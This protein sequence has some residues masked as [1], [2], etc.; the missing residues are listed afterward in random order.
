M[1]VDSPLQRELAELVVAYTSGLATDEQFSRLA[2][3]IG[4]SDEA[5]AFY[6]DSL[7]LHANLYWYRRQQDEH[8]E[9]QSPQVAS[10]LE[11]QSE[12]SSPPPNID[13]RCD[14]PPP[15]V[16]FLNL[17]GVFGGLSSGWLVA[18]S[19]AT[20][21]FG[22]G[23]AIGALV[24]VSQ[25]RHYAGSER[26]VETP[27]RQ[28]AIPNPSPI[29]ARVIGMVDC[30]WEGAG[31]RGPAS[32]AANQKSEIRN[33][34]SLLR[35]GDRLALTSGLLE[36]AYDTGARVI[37]QGPVTYDVESPAGG[38]LAVGKLT[39]KLGKRSEV[40]GPSSLPANQKSEIRNQKFAVRTPA[41]IVT[42]LGTE[43][44]VTVSETGVTQVHVIQGVVEAKGT[45]P[46][47]EL[48]QAKRLTKG[49]AIEIG[50]KDKA[51][52]PVAFAPEQ[53]TRK[54]ELNA[55]VPS[56]V[57]YMTAVLADQP[58]AYWPLNEPAGSRRFADHSDNHVHGWGMRQLASGKPGPMQGESRA[59]ALAGNGG[60][61][62]GRH[63]HFALA[64]DFTVEA[65]I[66]PD[67]NMQFGVVIAATDGQPRGGAG[68]ALCVQPRS[69]EHDPTLPA[70]VRLIT[71]GGSFFDFRVPDR[72]AEDGRWI[73][74]AVV[75]QESGLAQFYLNGAYR[76]SARGQSPRQGE[77]AWVSIGS[78]ATLSGGDWCGRLSHVAV[79]PRA[80]GAEQIRNHHRQ[81]DAGIAGGDRKR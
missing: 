29:V 16:P 48:S 59:V 68:W 66:C 15:T 36:I 61:D 63:D 65:W 34:K 79:Y 4:A 43:F 27:N 3:L 33:H 12:L 73:H 30:V 14:D 23:L 49:Q 52:Q 28:S 5:M 40:R 78:D 10:A 38:Y 37:L 53:F 24:H 1:S 80:L 20:V 8:V 22:I 32:A 50:Q 71:S 62:C 72:Q 64:G 69:P 21:I 58:L 56:E 55:G 81:R 60:I 51:Y 31:D 42:D 41:A 67:R 54:L 19:A 9:P 75:F 7:D 6:V 26:S 11:P 18:Y 2:T 70:V 46:Q 74:V 39:A 76:E 35:L 25:P 45:G 57:P 44:G 77:A 47:A 17:H 13:C